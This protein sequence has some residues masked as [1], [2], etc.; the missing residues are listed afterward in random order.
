MPRVSLFNHI[1]EL[2]NSCDERQQEWP[3]IRNL[4]S[5]NLLQQKYEKSITVLTIE[6][7]MAKLALEQSI[8][9]SRALI[10]AFVHIIL[11]DSLVFYFCVTKALISIEI[12]TE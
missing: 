6:W 7:T 1:P 5:V 8:Q 2:F 3:L 4:G 12:H 10:Y 11:W 9:C